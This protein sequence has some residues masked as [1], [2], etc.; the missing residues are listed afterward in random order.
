M[1]CGILVLVLMR[2][3]LLLLSE[4]IVFKPI[5]AFSGFNSRCPEGAWHFY[6][7]FCC[8]YYHSSCGYQTILKSKLR[9]WPLSSLILQGF[10]VTFSEMSNPVQLSKTDGK[11]L[12]FSKKSDL[13]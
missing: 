13:P 6:E 2:L 10:Q 1:P 3:L 12:H 5:K 11:R 7:N 9:P 4:L 8:I